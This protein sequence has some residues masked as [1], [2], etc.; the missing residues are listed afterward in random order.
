MTKRKV[1]IFETTVYHHLSCS[2]LVPQSPQKSFTTTSSAHHC[3][4]AVCS[5]VPTIHKHHT[6]GL[7]RTFCSLSQFLNYCLCECIF[8]FLFHALTDSSGY[9]SPRPILTQCPT[10]N[11]CI[12]W[13]NKA[14]YYIYIYITR[15]GRLMSHRVLPH[16][17]ENRKFSRPFFWIVPGSL[18]TETMEAFGLSIQISDSCWI[19]VLQLAT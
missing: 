1:D 4:F 10:E 7:Q 2:L 17:S 3:N 18:K 9:A 6:S 15:L 19:W 5:S 11:W 13:F 12:A 8:Y 16:V 14:L